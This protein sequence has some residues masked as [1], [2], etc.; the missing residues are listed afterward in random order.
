M[1]ILRRAVT[2]VMVTA[3]LAGFGG[4]AVAHAQ[5]A[6]EQFEKAVNSIGITAGDETDLPALGKNVCNT[7]TTEMAKNPNPPPVVRGIVASLQ[8]SN[9]SRE[10]AVGFM[11]A[12]VVIYCPQFARFIGR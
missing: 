7:L 9:L 12:S 4:A 2:V 5:D 1:T 10:Q 8:N 6:D 3:G 11:Q